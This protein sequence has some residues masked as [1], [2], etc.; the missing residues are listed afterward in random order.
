MDSHVSFQVCFESES[1]VTDVTHKGAVFRVA[2]HVAFDQTG[3]LELLP[4]DDTGEELPPRT[5]LH[6]V[7]IIE[8]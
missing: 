1:F 2:G 7:M 8:P 4:T 3:R 6:I 5:V